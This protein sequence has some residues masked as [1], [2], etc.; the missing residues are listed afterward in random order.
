MNTNLGFRAGQHA[1]RAALVLVFSTC[2]T[3]AAQVSFETLVTGQ[4]F[5]GGSHSPG[6]LLFTEDGINVTGQTYQ[7][8][9]FS[10]F[11]VATIRA[12]GTDLFATKHVFFDNINFGFDLSGVGPIN[13]V[14]IEY[15]EFGGVN[16]FSVNGNSILELPAMTSMPM[17]VAPGVMAMV[18]E[19]SIHL[20]GSITSFLIGGQELAI[21]NVVA[22]PEPACLALLVAGTAVGFFRR[23]R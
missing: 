20:T 7:T 4:T 6:Q 5:G 8:G 9:V 13:S 16:N 1:F 12:P 19:D 22:V 15:H 17:N 2:V 23:R 18:D 21:D 11:N 3:N 10:D 14:M